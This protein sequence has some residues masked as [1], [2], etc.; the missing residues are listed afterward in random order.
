MSS[1]MK[2]F[3]ERAAVMGANGTDREEFLAAPRQQ[4]GVRVDV[5][6]KH[7]PVGEVID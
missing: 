7:V 1:T 6:V 5:P 3:R 2:S 4:H